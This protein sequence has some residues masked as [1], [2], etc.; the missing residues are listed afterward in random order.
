MIVVAILGILAAIAVPALTKYIRRSKTSE[1]RINLA[2]M[3]D[4]AASYFQSEHAER[5]DVE[6]LSSGGLITDVAPHRCPYRSGEPSGPTA[7]GTTP[8]LAV[9]CGSGPGGRCVPGTSGGGGYY[10]MSDWGDNEVWSGLGFQMEQGHFFHYNFAATNAASGFGA[11]RFTSQAFGDLD[12]DGLFSTFERT[13][14]ADELGVN[15]A[16]GLYFDREVE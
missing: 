9:D 12:D 5:G 7:A 13:G 1:A 6:V 4:G 11:C 2:K 16:A 8:S 14:A 3:F 10:A 15:A